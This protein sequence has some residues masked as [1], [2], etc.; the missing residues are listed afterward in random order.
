MRIDE[1]SD[2]Q[3]R[4]DYIDQTDNVNETGDIIPIVKTGKRRISVAKSTPQSIRDKWLADMEAQRPTQRAEYTDHSLF[5]HV[6]QM[7][8]G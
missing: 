1:S 7:I 6:S 2:G 3:S 4:Y 5:D 8:F